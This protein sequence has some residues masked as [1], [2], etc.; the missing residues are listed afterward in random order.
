MRTDNAGIR[1]QF[2]RRVVAAGWAGRP[3]RAPVHRR[4]HRLAAGAAV[5]VVAAAVAAPAPPAVAA[6]VAATP[7]PAVSSGQGQGDPALRAS[8]QAMVDAGASGAIGLVDDGT[9]VSRAA[10]GAARLDPFLP[11]RAGDQFR[12]GSITKSV[13]ATITLQ[14]V[15]EGRLRLDD[16]VERW[17]PG[18][19]P[20]GSAITIR[21]LLQHT[22]GL[23]NYT[24]DPAFWAAV[25]AEPFRN[26][27]PQD[28][29]AIAFSHD[30]LFA[31]GQRW[32]YSNTGYIVI[33]LLLEAVTRTP[34]Q[35]LVEQRVVRPLHLRNTFFA[36]SAR[37]RGPYAHG[38]LP[39]SLTGDGYVDLSAWS[40]TWG[41]AAG[42]LVSSASDMRRFYQA[43]LSGR[44]LRPRLLDQ[45]MTTVDTGLGPHYGLG[46]FTFDTP[47]GTIWGHDGFLPPYLSFAMTDVTGTRSA[48]LLMPT[49]PDPATTA[50]FDQAL[51]TVVCGMFDLSVPT[52]AAAP[53][54]V[55]QLPELRSTEQPA[56]A[57]VRPAG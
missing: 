44:L 2:G 20:N 9:R 27:T 19:V 38:Y 48:V 7:V 47:C 45:M 41:W 10:V 49:F 30:P 31:P 35:T 43:L 46:L 32:S 5:A 36:T 3:L 15:G 42:A 57:L 34:V 50:A 25:N 16:S 24:D 1:A 37:F 52:G 51:A 8:L 54:L 55:S 4:I 21:M 14:L 18:V 26:W 12:M 53:S 29:L 33:G 56:T 28:L 40:P 39:P 22:S 11:M 17:L 6:P 23:F 13:I